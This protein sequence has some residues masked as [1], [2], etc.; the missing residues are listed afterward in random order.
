[1]APAPAPVDPTPL[2][3]E[4]SKAFPSG[5]GLA[6]A[7]CGVAWAWAAAAVWI[8]CVVTLGLALAFPD[9]LRAGEDSGVSGVEPVFRG[10]DTE[11]RHFWWGDDE[12]VG[13]VSVRS[14]LVFPDGM[15]GAARGES[16]APPSGAILSNGPG[17]A[18]LA[19]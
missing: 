15:A 2:P 19:R 7:A 4:D 13:R 6:T 14:W 16:A 12:P 5:P 11:G 18:R 8:V 3:A 10:A 9:P 1:V 17:K